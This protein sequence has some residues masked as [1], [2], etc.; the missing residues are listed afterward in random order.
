MDGSGGFPFGICYITLLFDMELI[1]LISGNWLFSRMDGE[2][3]ELINGFAGERS[4][5]DFLVC[6]FGFGFG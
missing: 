2:S 4:F 6:F 1:D 3:G 5:L